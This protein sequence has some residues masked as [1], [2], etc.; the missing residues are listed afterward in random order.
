MLEMESRLVATLSLLLVLVAASP[1]HSAR[2]LSQQPVGVASVATEPAGAVQ[3]DVP[4]AATAQNTAPLPDAAS[5]VT[6]GPEVPAQAIPGTASEQAPVV[7][8]AGSIA[9]STPAPAGHGSLKNAPSDPS[10]PAPQIAL[11][12]RPN[13]KNW[14][15]SAGGSPSAQSVQAAST[16]AHLKYYGGPVIQ[17]VKVVPIWYGS[18]VA[19]ATGT[20]NLQ[21]FYR[22][23]TNSAYM[24]WLS[25]YKTTSPAQT[26]GEEGRGHTG[27]AGSSARQ[28]RQRC[29][30]SGPGHMHWLVHTL[31]AYLAGYPAGWRLVQARAKSAAGSSNDTYS[32]HSSRSPAYLADSRPCVCHAPTHPLHSQAVAHSAPPSATKDTHPP[33]HPPF[34]SLSVPRPHPPSE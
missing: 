32:I 25:E 24:D 1:A 18:N 30:F 14:K 21:N 26:I 34:Y 33:T 31:P 11:Q 28:D 22:G 3:Q 7:P 9:P 8:G 23:I 16:T 12:V 20:S 19:Y 4:T 13:S 17:N 15:Q 6:T 29:A 5:I 10:L 27:W 2:I